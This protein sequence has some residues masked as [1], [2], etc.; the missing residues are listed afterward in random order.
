MAIDYQAERLPMGDS[1]WASLLHAIEMS[2]PSDE[3]DWVE[4]K[5]R[6]DPSTK[7]GGAAL[8]KGIVAFANRQPEQAG[9][10]L[11]G[12]GLI[13]VGLEPGNVLGTPAIDPAALHDQVDRYL[14]PPAPAWDSSQ[15]VYKGQNVLVV[16]IAP[17]RY[18]DR[19]AVVS[20]DGTDVINGH[21]YVRRA[22]K[23]EPA[24]HED[25]RRLEARYIAGDRAMVEIEVDVDSERPVSRIGHDPDWLDEWISAERNRLL[26]P[27]TPPEPNPLS[28]ILGRNIAGLDSSLYTTNRN[29]MGN[30]GIV[31]HEETRSED[32]FR[33]EV[34]AYLE[35]AAAKLP[36]ALDD[37][38]AHHASEHQFV[39]NNLGKRN[40]KN[41]EVAV[42]IEGD[43]FGV[44]YEGEVPDLNE[45]AGKPPREWGPWTSVPTNSALRALD[46]IGHQPVLPY[47][48]SPTSYAPRPHIENGGSVRIVFPSFDLRPGESWALDDVLLY[49]GEG[50][51]G[52][53][54]VTW[55]ATATNV[56]A[57]AEGKATLMIADEPID[58]TGHLR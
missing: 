2:Q 50:M 51:T 10:W 47:V 26:A 44:D 45:I 29:I 33:A 9:R 12:Y 22:G 36:A 13:V 19:I 53:T 46:L 37:L 21:I 1:E 3:T 34:D 23:S 16:T 15:H 56:D 42:Y 8:A 54:R 11:G 30:F 4:H 17:P 35:S 48:P 52:A 27:L 43:V 49:A 18:G 31:E 6:L 40:Y 38:R 32:E 25:L 20:K 14:A 58:V 7:A 55:T 28:S 39:V 57:V 41:L 5:A 24:R